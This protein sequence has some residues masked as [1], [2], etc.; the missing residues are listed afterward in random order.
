MDPLGHGLLRR[1]GLQMQPDVNPP[2]YQHPVVQLDLAG[3]CGFQPAIRRGNLTRLQRASKGARE[4]TR[5]SRDDVIQGSGV[6]LK[7]A[8]RQLIVLRHS[9]VGAKDHRFAFG[10]Q[11]GPANGSPHSLDPNLGSINDLC[12]GA[13]PR[14]I[15]MPPKARR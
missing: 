4:S 2:D 6:L 8:R 11:V 5:R 15:V 7:R 9:T 13:T 3:A 12:H 10:R 14:N 1:L